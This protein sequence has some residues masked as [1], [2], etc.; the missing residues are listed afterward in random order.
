[1]RLT[2]T[3]VN[4]IKMCLKLF[5]PHDDIKIYLYGSR[6][7]DHLKGGD[8]DLIWVV[9]KTQEAALNIDKYKILAEIK[10]AIGD[11]KIDL[12]ILSKESL[13]TDVFYSDVFKDAVLL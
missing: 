6:R 3:E 8:I 12:G 4:S 11:Q 10:T 7:F 1:M 2:P 5:L 9:P 13:A